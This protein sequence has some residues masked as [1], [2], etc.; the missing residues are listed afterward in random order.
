MIR[1][2]HR[3]LLLSVA[4]STVPF[5][6]VSAQE[7]NSQSRP[8]VFFDCDGRNCDDQYYRTEIDWVNWV[9]DQEV[10]DVHV[11]MTS[12]R[13]GTG[14]LEYRLDFLGHG[15]Q[16]GYDDSHL[17]QTLSTDTDREQLDQVSH[18]LG[19][20][21]ALFANT[22][23]YRGLVTLEGPDPESAGQGERLVSQ[24][25][26]NDPWNLWSF[27]VTGSANLDGESTRETTR[28]TGSFSASRVT[29]TWKINLRSNINH[30][31]VDIELDEGNFLDVR[32]DYGFNPLIV[33]SIADH[34][35]VGFEGQAGRSTRTNQ[36][37]RAEIS[38]GVE[39]S[40]FPYD[41]ATRRSF[42]FYYKVGPTY[43]DYVETTYL[44]E[45]EE[46]RFEESLQIQFSQRQTWGDAS[47]SITGSHYMH[48]F[49]R[50]NLSLRGDIDFRIVRGF[51][52]NAR[53]DIAWVNDQLYLSA[54]GT[55]DEE[56][57]LRLSQRAT[58]FNYGVQIGFSVQFGSI[59]NN[60]VNN[61]FRRAGFAGFTGARG[62]GF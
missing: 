35:S 18:M 46:T 30:N 37:F 33:Y 16:D 31:R 53:G 52:V 24:D 41:E 19:I 9:R 57:L 60:V 38:P 1:S 28:I 23:G 34:W 17:F 7:G 29:P 55:T 15:A 6:G 44:G 56:A 25:E 3:L 36:N 40:V 39:Y 5:L 11:I 43:R 49:E 26:V 27:R 8:N 59:F 12:L 13:T 20:G 61:R 45:D 50:N 42:T 62:R 14:G 51:S 48:D 2:I 4:V 58:S 10:A 54:Q 47:F 21:L 32:T 22:A